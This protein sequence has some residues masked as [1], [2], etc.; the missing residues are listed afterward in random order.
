MFG[1]IIVYQGY[2]LLLFHLNWKMPSVRYRRNYTLTTIVLSIIRLTKIERRKEGSW[3]KFWQM[4]RV[5]CIRLECRGWVIVR[6]VIVINRN[7][8]MENHCRR[9]EVGKRGVSF[10]DLLGK[11]G[12]RNI[13]VWRR[14]IRSIRLAE[15]VAIHR[16]VKNAKP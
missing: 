5:E 14:L 9:W 12:H 16:I 15:I 4:E 13:F 1:R 10:S 3:R 7:R 11:S 2:R 6:R 8:C